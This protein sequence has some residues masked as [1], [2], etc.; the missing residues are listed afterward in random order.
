VADQW[1]LASAGGRA[2]GCGGAG[3]RAV[4]ELPAGGGGNRG[5]KGKGEE[6]A[7]IGAPVVGEKK[8]RGARGPGWLC[9]R[10]GKGREGER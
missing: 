4:A 10:E 9:V 7:D 3:P 8:E 1:D 6:D 5:G 2:P